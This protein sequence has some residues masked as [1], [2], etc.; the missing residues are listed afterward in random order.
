MNKNLK[1]VLTG[2]IILI[3]GLLAVSCY[4][5]EVKAKESAVQISALSDLVA[6]KDTAISKLSADLQAK[7]KELDAASKELINVRKE[8]TAA[9]SRLQAVVV[10]PAPAAVPAKMQAP[11]KK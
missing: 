8:L 5:A 6:Q 2:L 7:Q 1:T 4:L 3:V 9:I 10:P 11:V